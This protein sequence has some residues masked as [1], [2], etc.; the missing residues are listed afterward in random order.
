MSRVNALHLVVSRYCKFIIEIR[1]GESLNSILERDPN[2]PIT[3]K[4][5]LKLGIELIKLVENLHSLGY[6]HCDIKPDNILTEF[7]PENQEQQNQIYL[8]DFGLV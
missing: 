3:E 4:D 2:S 5:S 7:E 6:A 8:I 1:L